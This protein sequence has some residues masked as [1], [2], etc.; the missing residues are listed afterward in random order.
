MPPMMPPHRPKWNDGI[1]KPKK[2]RDVPRFV[3]LRIK[4]FFSRLGLIIGLVWRSAPI[5]LC[6]MMLFCLAEGFL[7][8]I[9][10]YISR[11]LLN[12]I[13]SMLGKTVGAEPLQALRPILFLLLLQV[14][15][16]FF[17]KV[18]G[19]VNSVVTSLAGEKVSNHIRVMIIEKA[20][21]VDL[22][23]FDRPEFYEKLENANR[24]AGMRPVRIIEATFR[25][26]STIISAVSFVAVLFALSPLAPLVVMVAAIPSA[27]L[28]YYYRQRNFHYIR[29]HSKERREMSYYSGL[30]VNKD[31]VKEIKLLGLGDTFI[32][33]YKTVFGKYFGGLRRLIVREGVSQ[34]L[35][36]L[37]TTLAHGALFAYVAYHVVYFS[38]E[39]GDYSLYSGALSSIGGYVTTLVTTTAAIYEGTLFI[40]NMIAFM[41]EE[42]KVVCSLPEPRETELGAKHTITFDHVSFAYPGSDRLVL[43]DLSFEL[44]SGERTVLVGLNGAGK[45][46]LVKL[47]TRLYDPTEGRILLDG[48][49][50]REYDPAAYHRM[51]GIIFQDFGKYADTVAENVRYGDVHIPENEERMKKALEDGDATFV[52]DLPLGLQTPLTRMFYEDGLEL[53]GGMWQKLSLA[54]AFYREA[55]FLILDEPTAALDPLAEEEVFRRFYK[56]SEGKLA[57]FV[58]HRLSGATLADRILVVGEGRVLENGTHAELMEKQGAYYRLFSTQAIRYAEGMDDARARAEH[59]PG[60]PPP[61]HGMPRPPMGHHEMPPMP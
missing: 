30:M 20:K 59:R 44:S 28:S 14:C 36:S 53:S 48:K 49:D 12:A 11:D 24:E 38:A 19:R 21:E 41:K 43:K 51:F 17:S 42:P 4:G 2:L 10:A 26:A 6:L 57:L 8:V 29:F 60:M 58:S 31:Q 16:S 23:S 18:V 54:R 50:V 56:L 32:E 3:Y 61:M 37:F 22:S 45:T 5:C 13:A 46:T 7:P 34:I 39:I 55:D 35:V 25:V 1:E 9:G 40:D 27:A 52:G 33:K 47:L 15:H